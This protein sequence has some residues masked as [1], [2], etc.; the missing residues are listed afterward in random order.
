MRSNASGVM[1]S[2]SS[3]LTGQP[4]GSQVTDRDVRPVQG[5]GAACGAGAAVQ[6]APALDALA[7]HLR[8]VQ[9]V[10]VADHEAL[11]EQCLLDRLAAVG[12]GVL[13]PGRLVVG[14]RH[15]SAL[16]GSDSG[17]APVGVVAADGDEDPVLPSC[18]VPINDRP[19]VLV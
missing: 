16:H 4:L 5:C 14:H 11:E 12:A 1:F 10:L 9:V 6:A 19:T 18:A 2:C 15:W 13:A 17:R 3:V 7:R 8:A